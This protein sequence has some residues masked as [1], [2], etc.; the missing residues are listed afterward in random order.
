M[1]LAVLKQEAADLGL[2]DPRDIAKYVQDQQRDLRAERRERE[3]REREFAAAQAMREH[4]IRMAEFNFKH[5]IEVL[6]AT[7]P[8]PVAPPKTKLP[9]FPDDAD[10]VEAYFLVLER[11]AADHGWDE[12]T[13]FLQLVTRLQ[14]H[15]LDVYHRTEIEGVLMSLFLCLLAVSGA[16]AALHAIKR[17]PMNGFDVLAMKPLGGEGLTGPN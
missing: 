6:K 16:F 12:K 15:S 2:T 14:G 10:Q 4:E 5:K 13:M 9:M 7:L 17:S 1:D 3:D 11:V 8:T